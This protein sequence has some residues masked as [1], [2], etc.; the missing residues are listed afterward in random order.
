MAALMV[1]ASAMGGAHAAD[2]LTDPS[3]TTG[4]AAIWGQLVVP[5]GWEQAGPFFRNDC[6]TIGGGGGFVDFCDEDFGF[7]ADARIHHSFGNGYAIQLEGLF[8]YHRELD[9]ADATDDEHTHHVMLG[10]HVIKRKGDMAFGAFAGISGTG[11]LDQ[12]DQST[13]GFIGAEGAY[14]MG[15]NTFFGQIGFT[16]SLGGDDEVD[17]L[18]FGRVGAR[19]FFTEN[20]LVEGWVGGGFT[21][22]A[23]D[24]TSE[25]LNWLQIG[26]NFE[27]KLDDKPFSVFV[28]YQGDYVEAADFAVSGDESVFVSTFKLGLRM[29]WGDSL[30]YENLNGARTFDLMNQRAP[31]SYSDEL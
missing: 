18:I 8:D 15:Y 5:S 7:G 9:L 25:E 14:F 17:N 6:D 29:T 23:E 2:E 11:H 3:R 16:G 24:G 19:H 20:A 22:D 26:A 4:N 31:L 12:V 10:G 21:D 1:S 30:K 27:R 13:H 28:G